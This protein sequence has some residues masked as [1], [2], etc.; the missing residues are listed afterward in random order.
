MVTPSVVNDQKS[1]AMQHLAAKT[2]DAALLLDVQYVA[3]DEDHGVS[4]QGF[5]FD[6]VSK[7][8]F[9]SFDVSLII[10]IISQP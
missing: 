3:R 7:L 6:D 5:V 1:C 10:T 8:T 9:L 4:A 2:A